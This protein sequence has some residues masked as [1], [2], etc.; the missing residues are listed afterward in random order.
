MSSNES[1]A[2]DRGE[3]AGA[4]VGAA[5][6]RA[7]DKM[8]AGAEEA[9]EQAERAGQKAKVEAQRAGEEAKRVARKAEDKLEDAKD[10]IVAKLREDGVVNPAGLGLAAFGGIFIAAVPLTS[11]LAQRNGLLEGAVNGVCHSV[12]WLGSAGSTSRVAQT[13]KIAALSTLYIA[14]TYAFS[15]AG[16]AAGKAASSE[17]GLDPNHPRQQINELQGLPLRLYSAH[18]NLMEMFGGFGL[19]AALTAAIAPTDQTLINLLGLHVISKCFIYYPA[20]LMKVSIPRTVAHVLATASVI[21]VAL[22]LAKR[23]VIGGVTL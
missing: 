17:Q 2:R 4:K 16:S 6:G 22:T 15:G 12:A 21:N 5:A 18:A 10:T 7:A 14:M 11:W 1:K 13:G 19:T 23:P 20:Y 9:K 3:E 8:E